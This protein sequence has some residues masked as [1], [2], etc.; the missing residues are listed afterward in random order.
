[1]AM[2]S[3]SVIVSAVRYVGLPSDT[4]TKG[5]YP[6]NP[7]ASYRQESIGKESIGLWGWQVTVENGP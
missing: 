4:M 2:A 6:R 1:M 5:S 7:P 3:P